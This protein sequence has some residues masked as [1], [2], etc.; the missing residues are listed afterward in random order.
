MPAS[1]DP[2]KPTVLVAFGPNH[3][4]TELVLTGGAFA[5]HLLRSDQAGLAWNFARD[6][7]RGRDKL[8]DLDL[9][10]GV[11]GS[12]VLSACLAWCE[13]RVGARYTTGDRN[14]VWGD[15]VAGSTMG[16]GTAEQ[17]S[18]GTQPASSI[19]PLTEKTFF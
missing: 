12:P 11:T 5:A 9:R 3:F 17:A 19:A 7:G 10:T 14:F 16:P 1:L 8:A 15:V 13:C 18:S 6:G 4:T 2:A